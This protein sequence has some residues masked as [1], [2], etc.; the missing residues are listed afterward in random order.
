MYNFYFTQLIVVTV[1]TYSVTYCIT[2]TEGWYPLSPPSDLFSVSG[3]TDSM[4][5]AVRLQMR[6]S[7]VND[8]ADVIDSASKLGYALLSP[9]VSHTGNA[10]NLVFWS[11]R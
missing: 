9:G 6:F 10:N 4:M 8:I 2:G 7:G 5:G 3:T 11:L 1:F